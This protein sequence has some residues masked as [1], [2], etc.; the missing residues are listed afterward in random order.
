MIVLNA[1]TGKQLSVLPIGDLCDGLAFDSESGNVFAA[2][3]GGTMTIVHQNS[4]DGGYGVVVN[5]TTKKGARTI[6]ED[7]HSHWAYLPTA[8]FEPQKP[9]NKE[10]PKM[11]PG[12][13]QIL[14]VATQ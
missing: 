8:N 10:R 6:T 2:N 11:I 4:K 3:G 1:V 9:D 13:F 5:V 7:I 12:S 14:V